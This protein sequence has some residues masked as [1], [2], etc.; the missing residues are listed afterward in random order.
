MPTITIDGTIRHFDD[1]GAG[2]AVILVHGS[3]SNCRQWRKLN[4]RLRGRCRLIAPD[5]Y[6]G[7]A[8]FTFA[9]DRALVDRL[10]DMAGGMVHLVGHSY[11][12]VIALKTAL[13]RRDRLAGLILIEPSCFH[14]L[15]Q[16]GLPEY[17]EIAELRLRQ[18]EA[19][20]RGDADAS[21][22]VFLDY[23]MGEQTWAQMPE[24]RKVPI[25]LGMRKVMQDWL[26]THDG[27][28]RLSDLR[29][30]E[31]PTLLMRA[32]DTRRPSSRVVD[33]MYVTLPNRTLIEIEHGGHMSPL[34]NPDPVNAAIEAFLD[35]RLAT[36]PSA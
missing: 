3:V 35:C 7:E 16:E 24:P 14:L 33:L 17:A 8:A 34:T 10:L 30:F 27:S 11:G 21:A 4:E 2:G 19:L 31:V 5:L 23:W 15:E 26:G 32:K 9:E 28:P 20:A 13:A 1:E 12:G 25:R 22:G 29:R 36:P 6:A 18:G